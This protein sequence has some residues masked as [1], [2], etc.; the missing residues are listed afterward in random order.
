LRN[1][2]SWRNREPVLHVSWVDAA[3][4]CNWLSTQRGLTP[5]YSEQ[6]ADPA[7]PN[8]KFWTANFSADGFRLPTE[9]EWEYV[10]TGRGEA[11]TYPWG[12]DAPVPDFH[13]RFQLRAKTAAR[14]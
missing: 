14:M 4:Y 12:E 1:G 3:K 7:K 10:A 11:R 5:A 6:P 8:E 9:A 13:G 2:N